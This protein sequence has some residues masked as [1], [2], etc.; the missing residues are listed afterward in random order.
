VKIDDDLKT[1]VEGALW[2]EEALPAET[3]LAGLVFCDRVYARDA[4]GNLEEALLNQ[5]AMKPLALQIGGK[6][7]VG[8]GRVRCLF[9]PVDGGAK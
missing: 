5:F 2:N 7:T 4:E 3:I 6:A 1:V 8:R 9:T